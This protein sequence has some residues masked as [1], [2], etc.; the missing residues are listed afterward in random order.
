L[1]RIGNLFCLRQEKG[2]GRNRA[3]VKIKGKNNDYLCFNEKKSG[4]SEFRIVDHRV[5]KNPLTLQYWYRMHRMLLV[6]TW[7]HTTYN[8]SLSNAISLARRVENRAVMG[9][10][11]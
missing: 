2:S 9:K 4:D 1:L 10:L 3:K 6:A 7:Q 5:K 8:V 11:L